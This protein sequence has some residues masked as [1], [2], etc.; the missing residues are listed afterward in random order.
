MPVIDY[1]FSGA[2]PFALLGHRAFQEVVHRHGATVRFRPVSIAGIWAE[3]GAVMPAK[4]PPVRQRYRLI[5]L[6]RLR[7][8]RGV[9]INLKP[10]HHPTDITLA[11]RCTIVVADM[12]ETPVGPD[13]SVWDW[14]EAVGRGV[15]VDEADMGDEREILARL[16]ATGHGAGALERARTDAVAAVHEANTRAAI[17]A[18]AVGVPAYVYLGEV[19]WGQD[20]IAALDAMLRSGREPFSAAA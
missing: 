15:W 1:F 14:A 20:R 2:S 6:Q 10:K 12:G 3:S 16:D 8:E 4:R 5:E 13:H 19:F 11:D 17:E 9:P 7:E 18:D